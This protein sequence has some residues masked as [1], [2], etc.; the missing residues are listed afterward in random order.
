MDAS[1]DNMYVAHSEPGAA[2]AAWKGVLNPDASH[3]NFES[4]I[5]S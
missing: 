4:F 3:T 5:K 1:N 2:K